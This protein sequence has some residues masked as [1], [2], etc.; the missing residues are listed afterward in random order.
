MKPAGLF[1]M[2]SAW[3]AAAT[4][5]AQ[6]SDQN[7]HIFTCR[8]PQGHTLTGDHPPPE[9]ANSAIQE[10][11]RSGLLVRELPAP[12]TPEQQRQKDI[13][14]RKKH[15]AEIQ[16]LEQTR[17]DRALLTTYSNEEDLEAARERALS[18]YV[19]ALR[20]ANI[21]MNALQ[22]ERD[23][24]NHDAAAYKGK[25]LPPEVQHRIDVNEAA[26]T[27]E[28]HSIAERKGAMDRINARFDADLERFRYLMRQAT[29]QH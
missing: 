25:A 24:N 20:L 19:E 12:L 29:A 1:L 27:A 28:T 7:A 11:T 4:V 2:L 5:H 13:D 17:K 22:L 16:A 9:C 18:D 8:D 26:I 21:N 14:D 6:T 10:R 3:L 23:A 15:E